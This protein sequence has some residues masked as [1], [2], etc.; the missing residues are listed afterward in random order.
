MERT[1]SGDAPPARRRVDVPGAWQDFVGGERAAP[2]DRAQRD[3]VREGEPAPPRRHRAPEPRHQ[4]GRDREQID[5]EAPIARPRVGPLGQGGGDHDTE[6]HADPHAGPSRVARRRTR[7]GPG[8]AGAGALVEA[9]RSEAA[10][11][12]RIRQRRRLWRRAVRAELP[13]ELVDDRG[14]VIAWPFNVPS[15]CGHLDASRVSR[16]E[17]PRPARGSRARGGA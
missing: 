11:R 13:E 6:P 5:Q 4:H 17:V 1:A 2:Q 12:C 9:G 15:S 16:R 10:G 14:V 8:G 3:D 7:G